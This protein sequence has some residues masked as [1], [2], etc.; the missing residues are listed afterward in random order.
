[1]RFNRHLQSAFLY[2]PMS[3]R[4][5]AFAKASTMQDHAHIPYIMKQLRL[6][7][8]VAN[9]ILVTLDHIQLTSGFVAPILQCTTKPIGYINNSFLI[10]IRARLAEIKRSLWIEKAWTPSAQ[11]EGNKSLM[12]RFIQ[13]PRITTGILKKVNTVQLYLQIIIIAD[14]VNPEHHNP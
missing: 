10:S 3:M 1:M 5:M 11:R 13:I 12:D 9:N 6:D 7:K 2:G 14:L 4:G 8:T